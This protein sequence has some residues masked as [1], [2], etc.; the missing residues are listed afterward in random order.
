MGGANLGTVSKIFARPPKPFS[1]EILEERITDWILAP[2]T[3]SAQCYCDA[4][5]AQPQT[6]VEYSGKAH[7]KGTT[8][9]LKSE[10]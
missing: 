1:Y 9:E 3:A 5:T 6:A 2:L 8:F 10:S 4:Q 7:L